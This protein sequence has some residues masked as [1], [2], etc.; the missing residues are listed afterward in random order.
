MTST[1]PTSKERLHSF[2]DIK[3]NKSHHGVH[4]DANSAP[5]HFP[6]D[7]FTFLEPR[8]LESAK[9][10]VVQQRR[11]TDFEAHLL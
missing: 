4:L 2:V 1:R 3:L 10:Y 7:P 6:T 5:L 11:T 9:F 8:N